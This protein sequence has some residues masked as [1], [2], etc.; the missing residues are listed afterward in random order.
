MRLIRQRNCVLVLFLILATFVIQTSRVTCKTYKADGYE[1][2]TRLVPD[3][4]VIMLGEPI[5]VSFIVENHSDQD[6]QMLVGGDYRNGLGRPESFT[7]TVQGK[8]NRH[9]PQPGGTWNGR[10]LWPRTDTRRG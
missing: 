9:V 3:R 2:Q 4:T 10:R 6:L 5:H 7:V 1:I 8:G